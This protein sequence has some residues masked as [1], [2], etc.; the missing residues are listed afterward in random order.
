MKKLLLILA[1]LLCGG[2]SYA[3]NIPDVVNPYDG[4]PSP[5][6]D[7]VYNN[8]G[9]SLSVGDLV[10]WDVA[11]STGDD[12]AWVTTTTTANTNLVAGVVWPKAIAAGDRGSI[13]IRGPVTV[14]TSGNHAAGDGLCS[15]GT[16]GKVGV[17]SSAITGNRIGFAVAGDSSGTVKA[18]LK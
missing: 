7:S 14:N 1:L 11:S 12:D 3:A 5:W 17:C 15:S 4:G 10:V 9:S 2:V 6:V 18:F 16:A 13:V 8:S